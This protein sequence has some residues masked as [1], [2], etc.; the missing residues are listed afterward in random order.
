MRQIK[1]INKKTQQYLELMEKYPED[2]KRRCSEYIL[3]IMILQK[4]LENCIEIV[5]TKFAVWCNISMKV[6]DYS[7]SN[8]IL[9]LKKEL[10][11]LFVNYQLKRIS[12]EM[13]S[14]SVIQKKLRLMQER[15]K[16]Y[17]YILTR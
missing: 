8:I 7:E 3:D 5:E 2:A 1:K 13:L 16:Q 6:F 15:L 17:K 14:M 4:I 10:Y 12:Y 11:M 9:K